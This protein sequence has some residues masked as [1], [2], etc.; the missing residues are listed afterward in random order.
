MTSRTFADSLRETRRLTLLRILAE[1][2][3]YFANSSILHAGLMHLGVQ[4]DRDDVLTDLHWLK[5][6]GLVSM[7]EATPG[8][9]VATLTTR[10]DSVAK[11]HTI[12]PGIQRPGP[13]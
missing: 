10:G 6:Q 4:S 7:V 2:K 5:D 13:K 9:H 11:G 12:V 3:G 1:Q 8:V